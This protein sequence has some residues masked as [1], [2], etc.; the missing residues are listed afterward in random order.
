MK[1]AYDM[2]VHVGPDT[3]PRHYNCVELAR[4]ALAHEMA[5]I[6]LKDQMC[7]SVAKAILSS[8]AV[9]GI[10]VYGSWVLNETCGGLSPRS[11]RCAL[12]AGAKVIWLPTVDADYGVR[13]GEAGHWIKRV[14]DRNLFRG[15][16]PRYR[17]TDEKGLCR[18]GIREILEVVS[19]GDAVLGTGHISPEECLVLLCSNRGIGA[20]ILI[21]HPCMWPEDYTSDKLK[22][23]V[24]LGAFIEL[25]AGLL[26]PGRG[27]CD[28]HMMKVLIE[29]LG[30]EHFILSTDG[31]DVD[32]GPPP[33]ELRTFCLLLRSVGL[34]E[35][36]IEI[37]VRWNPE[38]LLETHCKIGVSYPMTS[39]GKINGK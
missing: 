21:T 30:A 13:K 25:T 32:W 17:L 9:P 7:P 1:G 15:P 33:Q 28:I 4:D 23:M 38:K 31:G 39:G 10:G 12:A 18:E 24:G 3:T 16:S 34:S 6:V 20:K 37:M 8:S 11:V 36:E 2:H 27:V 5:G 26:R 35:K 22:R 19:S 14:N 29:E